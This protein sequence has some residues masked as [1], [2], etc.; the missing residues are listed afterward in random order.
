MT[1][2]TAAD[3]LT[4]RRESWIEDLYSDHPEIGSNSDHPAV[5]AAAASAGAGA[6]SLSGLGYGTSYYA[7]G[8][9]AAGTRFTL[10]SAGRADAYEITM[11]AAIASGLATV[12]IS[13]ALVAAAAAGDR[14]LPDAERVGLFA[15]LKNKQFFSDAALEAIAK[16][17]HQRWALKISVSLDPQLALFHGIRFITMERRLGSDDYGA[18]L[19][20]DSQMT[21]GRYRREALQRKQAEDL[22]YL[23]PNVSGARNVDFIR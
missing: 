15:R 8:T 1:Y 9:I 20:S 10:L 11:S 21:A 6:L 14:V 2:L 12:Q 3:V 13:P 18:C 4:L 5:V 23:A 16:E 19:E 17:A 7:S 22:A